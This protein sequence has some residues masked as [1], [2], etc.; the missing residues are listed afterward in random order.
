[1]ATMLK[2]IRT[3][4]TAA[5]LTVATYGVATAAM[6]A[7]H[8]DTYTVKKGDTLWDIAG[9][10]LKKP[11]LWP[12]I[13]QANPQVKNPHL[14]YPGDVLSL[15]Y[16]DRVAVQEGPREEAP[17]NAI[18]LAEI[19]PFLKNLRVVDEFEQLP[20]VVAFEEDR[21]RGVDGQVVYVRGLA[22]A[23]P[24]QRYAVVRPNQ[25]NRSVDPDRCCENSGRRS[26]VLDAR[27]HRSW[28]VERLWSYQI[29]HG[30]GEFLGYELE[31]ITTGTISRGEGDDVEVS[32]LLIDQKGREVRAGDRLIAVDAQP[33]DL[34]FMPH[35]PSQQLDYDKARVIAV[36]DAVATGGPRDVIALSV[37][38]QDGIDNGTVLSTWRVGSEEVDRVAVG[39]DRSPD[40][41]GG[42]N[43]V[44]LPDEFSGHV[45]IFRTFDRVSYGLVMD[46][47]RPTRLGYALKHPD[48]T[49]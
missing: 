42:G 49:R 39:Y 36:A 8:P 17:I 34:Q 19:E 37:G 45:L 11:W 33:Y 1:M 32:T 22:D 29:P 24:G 35:P 4:L 38:A 16:L 15:A 31:Q 30:K 27:G 20:Y 26:E 28:G 10:F 7:D 47:L 6:Q 25:L 9:R 18:P 48:A 21:L 41:V 3:V 14:I 13:W 44:R 46:A 40:A 23:Q 12:E 2:P 43:H 5:L